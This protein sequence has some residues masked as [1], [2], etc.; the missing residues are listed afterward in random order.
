MNFKL[1]GCETL[2]GSGIDKPRDQTDSIIVNTEL[3]TRG[4][5]I[6]EKASKFS[7][8]RIVEFL[9]SYKLTKREIEVLLLLAQGYKGYEIAR[10]LYISSHTVNNHLRNLYRKLHVYS[11]M[12]A[13]SK[14]LLFM[15]ELD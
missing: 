13:V 9:L 5:I 3:S 2:R 8:Q 10:H 15:L 14:I 6:K 11:G 12:E 4:K 7:D 1:I